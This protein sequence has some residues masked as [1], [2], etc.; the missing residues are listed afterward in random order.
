MNISYTFPADCPI[1][2]LRGV[3]CEGGVLQRHVIR[4]ELVDVVAFATRVD[5]KSVVASVAGKP[6]LEAAVAAAKTAEQEA[7]AAKR[8][9]L[10][11]AVPGLAAYETAMA[12]YSRAAAAYDRASERGYPVAEAAAAKAAQQALDAV[13]AQYPATASWNKIIAYTQAANYDKSAAG[14]AARRTVEAGGDVM[15]AA[16]DMEAAWSAAAARAVAN[17]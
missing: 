12:A 14:D 11:A 13:Y 8:R 2:A 4:G 7:Q 3:T 1:P 10:E 6:E 5:G 17:A 15:Q 16:A 9:A